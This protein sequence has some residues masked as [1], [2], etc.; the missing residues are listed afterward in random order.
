MYVLDKLNHNID[1]ILNNIKKA[2]GLLIYTFINLYDN[3][4]T[5][6]YVCE[7]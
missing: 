2:V 6:Y 1:I 5:Y 3:I 4:G 7:S